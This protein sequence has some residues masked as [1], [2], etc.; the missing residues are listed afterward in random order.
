MPTS[1][2]MGWVMESDGRGEV[3]EA[4]RA[5]ARHSAET[6]R[7]AERTERSRRTEMR[8]R[9]RRARAQDR[10]FVWDGWHGR[11]AMWHGEQ[12]RCVPVGGAE[13]ARPRLAP[14]RGRRGCVM[15]GMR[16]EV[17]RSAQVEVCGCE[18]DILI[19]VLLCAGS[20]IF[21]RSDIP[22]SCRHLSDRHSS[23]TLRLTRRR[24][25]P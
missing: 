23:H 19:C 7:A 1:L 24:S 13:W 20:R 10:D 4:A 18:R 15:D 8:E 22:H 21:L 11:L 12:K 5:R 14:I 25:D 16:I 2:M 3:W 9:S 6:R 17:C